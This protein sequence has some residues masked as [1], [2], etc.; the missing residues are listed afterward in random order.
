M[1]LIL[2]MKEEI[3]SCYIWRMEYLEVALLVVELVEKIETE[4]CYESWIPNVVFVYRSPYHFQS[5]CHLNHQKPDKV[6]LSKLLLSLQ[7]V[8]GAPHQCPAWLNDHYNHQNNV[9]LTFSHLHNS[10]YQM[11]CNY[12]SWLY[13]HNHPVL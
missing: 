13:F 10:A 1:R 3:E 5:L 9:S 6:C 4:A 7:M 2:L 12:H 11:H 8:M